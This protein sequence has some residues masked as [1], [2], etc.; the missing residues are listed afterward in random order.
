MDAEDHQLIS[1]NAERFAVA[2]LIP[3][4]GRAPQAWKDL[5]DPDA[6]FVGGT[7]RTV[8]RIV[9]AAFRRLRS[10]GRLVAT[11]G[12]IENVAAV[13]QVLYEVAGDARVW[14]VNIAREVYQLEQV[15]FESLN[16][17]FLIGAVKEA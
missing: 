14:M 16:P 11:V 9:E 5:P 7:G 6:I 10:S 4:L 15:R 2:N 13:R 12:T 3:V 17:T 8:D 1:A